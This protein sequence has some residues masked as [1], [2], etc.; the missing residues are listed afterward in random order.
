MVTYQK[1]MIRLLLMSKSRCKLKSYDDLFIKIFEEL[2]K[3]PHY[4]EM[5]KEIE[6]EYWGSKISEFCKRT[7]EL[8]GEL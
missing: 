2:K 6:K 7:G 8:L 1:M 4:R 5:I 3:S